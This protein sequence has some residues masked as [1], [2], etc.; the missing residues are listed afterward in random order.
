V[1]NVSLKGKVIYKMV[2][3][4]KRIGSLQHFSGKYSVTCEMANVVMGLKP[5]CRECE[6]WLGGCQG[7][8]LGCSFS[9]QG[10][11]R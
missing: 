8:F 4:C 10:E 2:S 9:N 7:S 6:T 11:F 3:I 1:R 5:K